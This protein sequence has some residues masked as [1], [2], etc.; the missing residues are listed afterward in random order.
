M[1][2]T[3]L[4]ILIKLRRY[5]AIRIVPATY[6]TNL[7]DKIFP[8]HDFVLTFSCW[9]NTEQTFRMEHKVGRNLKIRNYKSNDYEKVRQI[10]EAGIHENFWPGL[11]RIWNR[12]K[13]LF[14]HLS[15]VTTFSLTSICLSTTVGLLG[16]ILYV[17]LYLSWLRNF[18]YG[19]AR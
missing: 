15:F 2:L 11:R 14:F 8:D 6:P 12:P 9:K 13:T 18:Y 5:Y 16:L 3:F 17:I 7:K 19:Y 1:Y 10:F 4:S